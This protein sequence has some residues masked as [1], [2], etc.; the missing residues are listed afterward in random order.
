MATDKKHLREHGSG[1]WLHYRIPERYKLLPECIKYNGIMPLNL[2]TD[3]LKEARRRRDIILHRLEAQAGERY[4]SWLPEGGKV[5]S[6]LVVAS[7]NPLHIVTT[8]TA[9]DAF[10]V[11]EILAKGT[12]MLGDSPTPKKLKEV[13]SRERDAV[14]GLLN[15]KRHSGDSL[16]QLT[17]QVAKEAQTQ[18]KA[19]A[20]IY[21]ITRGSSWFLSNLLQGDISIT[22]IDYDQ[23]RD[24]IH[25]ELERG[26]AGSTLKGHLYGLRQVWK[27]AKQSKLV[28]GDCPFDEHTVKVESKPFDPFTFEEIRSL[29]QN[30][31]GELKTLIHAAAMTGARVDELLTA[32]VKTPSTFEHPC[33]L[34]KFK[35]K[36]KTAQSTRVVPV[37]S[38]LPITDGF[39]FSLTYD[40]VQS[41][42][43]RLQESV[44]G[45]P[46][47]ELTGLPRKLSMHSFRSYVITEL[48]VTHRINEKVVGG[49]T[50]HL[51]GGQSK[52]GALRGY[53]HIEDL[54]KKREIVELLPWDA[55]KV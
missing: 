34:F 43:K 19:E 52:A 2:E 18:G 41:R 29:Y 26:V 24:F 17:E 16:K 49:V 23:V 33:W 28:S 42:L 46:L 6:G 40:S 7:D 27:R 32:E 47:H 50:G 14:F 53:I 54:S 4:N 20:T 9:R 15:T 55:G 30:A 45:Q 5:E 44:L 1:W 13:A 12:S 3:S 11:R 21:K 51:G 8:P 38:S 25:A 48:V 37:H 36:G 22:A 31:K 35:Q 39:Q 10:R